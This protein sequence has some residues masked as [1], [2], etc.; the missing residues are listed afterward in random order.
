MKQI[1]K[2]HWLEARVPPPIVAA[3]VALAMWGVALLATAHDWGQLARLGAAGIPAGLGL[4]IAFLG[5]RAFRR[6]RTTID[7]THLQAA[8]TLVTGG[9]YRYTR[10]P[11]YLGFTLLLVGWA[12]WLQS[13]WCLLGPVCFAWLITRFQIRPEERALSAR[14]GSHYADYTSRVRRWL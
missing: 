1:N 3:A 8:S 2:A 10:N 11:M 7:P 5:I 14:F 4:G 9:I 6:A 12:F 13:A